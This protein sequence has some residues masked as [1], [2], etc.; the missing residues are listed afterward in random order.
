MAR[1]Y[2]SRDAEHAVL[3]QVVAEHLEAFLRAVAKAGDG[4]G[5]SARPS[6]KPHPTAKWLICRSRCGHYL[7]SMITFPLHLL[8]LLPVLFGGHRQLALENL[9]LRQQL[10]VY[11]RMMARPRLRRT[12][13]IF[14]VG[15]ARIWAGWRQALVIVTPDTVVP[16]KKGNA[17]WQSV[18][19]GSEN[20]RAGTDSSADTA[21]APMTVSMHDRTVGAGNRGEAGRRRS[22]A[23]RPR[24]GSGDEAR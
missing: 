12:D 10:A 1:V 4:A 14:W 5:R 11:K 3:H 6:S 18:R 21:A 9:A 17:S 23:V 7:S 2:R 19:V 20:V 13:R 24:A 22:W 8:R 16:V 15:L